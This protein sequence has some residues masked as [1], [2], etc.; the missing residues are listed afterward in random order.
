MFLGPMV[1]LL[2]NVM[3]ETETGKRPAL[4]LMLCVAS[5]HKVKQHDIQTVK[6]QALSGCVIKT[7]SNRKSFKSKKGMR[8]LIESDVGDCQVCPW[9]RGL[10]E[11]PGAICV[12]SGDNQAE[13]E[14][15]GWH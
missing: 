3:I 7:I 9:C 10:A 8:I 13:Y 14:L 15:W 4:Q 12:L 5:H 2:I 1:S 11:E 6:H